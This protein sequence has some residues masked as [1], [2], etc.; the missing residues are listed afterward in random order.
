MF[1]ELEKDGTLKHVR[2]KI[3]E[4]H[5]KYPPFKWNIPD[6]DILYGDRVYKVIKNDDSVYVGEVRSTDH[7]KLFGKGI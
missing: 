2:D 7:T 4:K 1:F 6:Q 5:A 3:S